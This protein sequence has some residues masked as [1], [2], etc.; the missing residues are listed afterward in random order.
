MTDAR[1]SVVLEA[2][3]RVA[4]TLGELAA[5][6][7]NRPVAVVRELTKVF[8]EVW[9]GTAAEGAAAFAER[10]PRGEVVL[11]IGGAAPAEPL[12]DEAINAAVRRRMV[13][14][15]QEG[16]RQMADLL[17]Q[18]LRVARRRVYETVLQIRHESSDQAH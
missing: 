7:G 4:G 16:P 13:E 2:P 10:P 11:V 3:G 15:P 8:E 14:S 12:D 6:D 5:I 17:S 9:R 1:T 18:E